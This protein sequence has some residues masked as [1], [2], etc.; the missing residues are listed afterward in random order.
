MN[1]GTREGH[2]EGKEGEKDA[3]S[4]F[5]R[6]IDIFGSADCGRWGYIRVV[7]GISSFLFFL[8]ALYN[9]HAIEIGHEIGQTYVDSSKSIWVIFLAYFLAW[10]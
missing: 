4:L 3:Q 6:S 9:Y 1:N 5:H 2:R 8:E 10:S 7:M